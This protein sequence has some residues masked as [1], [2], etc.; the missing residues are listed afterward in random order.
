MFIYINIHIFFFQ[1]YDTSSNGIYLIILI[2][3]SKRVNSAWAVET[4]VSI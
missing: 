4:I 2:L 1:K 3:N